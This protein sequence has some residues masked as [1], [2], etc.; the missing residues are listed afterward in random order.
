[1]AIEVLS[2]RRRSYPCPVLCLVLSLVA[3]YLSPLT[4]AAVL[5]SLFRGVVVADSP[6]WVRVVSIEER[7]QASMADLRP[8][9]VIVRVDSRDVRSIDEFAM[10]SGALKGQARTTTLVIFRNGAPRE[11]LLH[12]YSYPILREWKVAFVPEDALRF[13]EPSVGRNYWSRLGRGFEEAGRPK[14]ALNAYLNGLHNLPTDTATAFK[15][16]ELLRALSQQQ[17]HDGEMVNGVTTL[18]QA[19][20]ILEHVFDTPLSDEQLA[21]VRQ[22]LQET[23]ET[24]RRVSATQRSQHVSL[25]SQQAPSK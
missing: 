15:V 24:L 17:L 3:C 4:Y 12:L 6:L 18:R 23:L 19:L 8:D 16:S 5:P 1:M 25:G 10:I 13:A 14:E 21:Q 20:L 9:D 2:V 11:I 7:S 22:R